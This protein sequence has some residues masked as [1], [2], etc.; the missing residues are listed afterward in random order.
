[1][2]HEINESQTIIGSL[3]PGQSFLKMFGRAQK[4]ELGQKRNIGWKSPKTIIT[5]HSIEQKDQKRKL[6]RGRLSE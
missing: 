4:I 3:E 6:L 2:I 5:V 1:M